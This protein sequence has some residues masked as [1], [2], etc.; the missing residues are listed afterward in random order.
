MP[1]I[2]VDRVDAQGDLLTRDAAQAMVDAFKPGAPVTFN[3]QPPP[4]GRVLALRLPTD[5]SIV[6]ATI[7]L[8]DAHAGLVEAGN[9][10]A[11]GGSCQ[12]TPCEGDVHRLEGVL[13]SEAALTD[14][15]V[16]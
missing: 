3:F 2:A 9:K 4:L 12:S 7:E 8:D 16:E 6:Y 14:K 11:I 13:L 15:K 10:L 1:L 5:E